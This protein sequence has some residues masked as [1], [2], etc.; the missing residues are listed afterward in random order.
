[1]KREYLRPK[2]LSEAVDYLDYHMENLKILSGGTDLLV[3]LRENV[4]SCQYIMDI[5]EIKEMNE[6]KYDDEGLTIG[7]AVSLNKIIDF[8]MPESYGILKISARNLAN[9]AIRNRATLVGNICNSSPGG[10][11]LPSSLVLGGYAVALSK[12]GE[13]KIL[14]KDFFTGVKKNVLKKNELLVKLIFPVIEGQGIYLKKQRIKGHDLAQASVAAY[15]KNDGN[16]SFS[17]GAVAPTPIIV[18]NLGVYK[19]EEL[20]NENVICDILNKISEKINPIGD[21]RASKEYR[22]DMIKYFTKISLISLSEV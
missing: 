6:I 12:D 17:L 20:R 13:R 18:E 3:L 22:L 11:M 14:L 16:L 19:K 8:N 4:L 10:D 1:M 7:G 5:K 9:Y 15:L 2:S 21:Q